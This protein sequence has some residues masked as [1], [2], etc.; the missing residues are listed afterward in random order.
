[1]CD[2]CDVVTL[3]MGRPTFEYLQEL[4]ENNKLV[5]GDKEVRFEFETVMAP[6]LELWATTQEKEKEA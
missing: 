4:L 1:M 2:R 5:D 3:K 6:E